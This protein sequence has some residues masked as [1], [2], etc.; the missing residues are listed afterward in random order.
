MSGAHA[1]VVC[2][3]NGPAKTVG[4]LW[5]RTARRASLGT[6]DFLRAR[7]AAMMKMLIM[8]DTIIPEAASR[9]SGTAASST[10]ATVGW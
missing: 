9:R 3:A 8:P 6:A 4:E 2:F 1:R 5:R 7:M 10:L